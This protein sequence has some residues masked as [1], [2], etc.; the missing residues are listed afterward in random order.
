M[1]EK[2]TKTSNKTDTVFSNKIRKQ[3]IKKNTETRQ[4]NKNY[5]DV[6]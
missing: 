1:S 4:K 2:H 3:Y 5:F 6:K